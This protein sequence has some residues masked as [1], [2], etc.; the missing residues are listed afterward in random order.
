MNKETNEQVEGLPEYVSELDREIMLEMI[1]ELQAL[2]RG[3]TEAF[4]NS[5][6][7]PKDGDR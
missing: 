6:E 1:E 2:G 3:F 7:E 5:R 4:A